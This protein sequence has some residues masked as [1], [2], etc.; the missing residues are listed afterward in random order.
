M[1]SH[2]R[3]KKASIVDLICF[4]LILLFIYASVSKLLDY[5][6][7]L[8]QL[9]KSPLLTAFAN[10]VV[11]LIPA[12]EILLSVFLST[13]KLCL[14]G[15]YGSFSLMVVFT[16]YII[17]ITHFAEYIPCSCGGVLQNMTWNQHLVFNIA[18]I[19]LALLGILLHEKKERPGI[20]ATTTPSLNNISAL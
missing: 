19:L 20:T 12:I 17:A 18:F 2:F 8:V 13:S 15:L 14:I 10:W 9:Q 11:I 4:L 7:F 16:A 1:S 3:L 6:K 5:E